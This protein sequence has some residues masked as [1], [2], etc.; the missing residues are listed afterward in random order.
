MAQRIGY[1]VLV[2]P[3]PGEA[4]VFEPTRVLHRGVVAKRR[5]R[6]LLQIVLIPWPCGWDAAFDQMWPFMRINKGAGF[7]ALRITDG[8]LVAEGSE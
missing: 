6:R 7:P 4:V 8:K 3:L 1:P 2:R 5:P